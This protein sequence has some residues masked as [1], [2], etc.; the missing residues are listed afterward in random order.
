MLS[1]G[2][3]DPSSPRGAL[4]LRFFF[5]K[6]PAWAGLVVLAF[7]P[8]NAV[9]G[10]YFQACRAGGAAF[11]LLQL[12]FILDYVV[13]LNER[14]LAAFDAEPW[15]RVVLVGGSLAANCGA[16]A[17]VACLYVYLWVQDRELAFVTVT[18]L[19]F[20]LLT[21]VSLL[22]STSGGLFT[23]GV[24]SLYCVYLCAAAILS[25]PVHSGPG[26]P[27]WLVALGFAITMTALLYSIFSNQL[28][29]EDKEADEA[30][31]GEDAEPAEVHPLRYAFF[32]L[33]FALAAMYGA[34]LFTNWS[35]SQQLV[36]REE[37]RAVCLSGARVDAFEQRPARARGATEPVPSSPPPPWLCSWTRASRPCG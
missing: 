34:M 21:A 12:V 11:L 5:W 15:A 35:S 20:V 22:P 10:Q 1:V 13:S 19:I 4:H 30:G 16:V 28:A 6:V 9:L 32:H 8:S 31:G 36:T 14:A 24:V 26:N 7:L 25:D 3:T 2:V 23:S 33:V 17:G 18:L 27:A 37:A 29:F